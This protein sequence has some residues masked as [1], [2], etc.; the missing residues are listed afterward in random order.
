MEKLTYALKRGIGRY[1]A[2][3]RYNGNMY[4]ILIKRLS[5][6]LGPQSMWSRKSIA[7]FSA[8]RAEK[9]R[10]KNNKYLEKKKLWK[11]TA[12]IGAKRHHDNENLGILAAAM[13]HTFLNIQNN[14]VDVTD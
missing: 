10:S 13:I 14:R 8:S 7:H 12:E 5:L 4:H 3:F 1:L 6:L 11:G 9:C 2:F